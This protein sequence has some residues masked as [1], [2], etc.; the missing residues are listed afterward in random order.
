VLKLAKSPATDTGAAA[1]AN[2]D[3]AGGTSNSDGD[4]TGGWALATGIAGL[5]AGLTGLVFGL[6][7]WRR[8]RV[9][10]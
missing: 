4:D 9:T 1:A 6:L 5:V 7:A 3:I 8:G 10:A 2:A